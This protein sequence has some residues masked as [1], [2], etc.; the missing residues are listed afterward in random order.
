MA[1]QGLVS[2]AQRRKR[3]VLFSQQQVKIWFQN[4]RY[5]HKRQDKER[6][7]GSGG[8]DNS[9]SPSSHDH[10]SDVDSGSIPIKAEKLEVDEKPTVFPSTAVNDSPCLPDINNPLYQ[11]AMYQQHSYIP[12]GITFPFPQGYP[13]ASQYPYSQYRL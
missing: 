11:Q 5:K 9:E 13:T 8:R 10:D 7:M 3:R 6:K 1:S 2:M 12:Q 4:Q